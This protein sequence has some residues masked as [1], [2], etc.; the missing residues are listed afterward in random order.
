MAINAHRA[1]ENSGENSY[2]KNLNPSD[3]EINELRRAR[4]KI[5]LTLKSAFSDWENRIEAK[6]LFEYTA[7]ASFSSNLEKPKLSPKFRSQ[8]SYVY[9]TLNQP[10]HNP[11]QEMDFDDGMFLPTS[12]ITQDGGAHP[13][14]ASEGYFALVESA[15]GPLC[16]AEGWTLNPDRARPSCVRVSLNNGRSHIDIALYAIP[17]DEYHLLIE[18]AAASSRIAIND[19][20]DSGEML[21]DSVY[22]TI[23]ID[24]IMLAHRDEGWKISD[25]RKLEDW[26]V[27]AVKTHGEQLRRVSRY[28]KG[29]RDHTWESCRLSSIALM[30][31]V[32]RF[33]EESRQDH[34]GRDDLA[35]QAVAANLPTYLSQKIDNPVV[36]GRLDEGWDDVDNPCRREFVSQAQSLQRAIDQA[37]SQSKAADASNELRRLFGSHFPQEISLISDEGSIGAPA[38]VSAGVLGSLGSAEDAKSAVKIGGDD[39]YG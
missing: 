32:V 16:R 26:F 2:R 9:A 21:F 15:L 1:F 17:D 35:L 22:Q 27:S 36:E 14:V 7:V 33:F 37:L 19:S 25:P 39:R 29:W 5:R 10:T 24:Q 18:K 28:L 3:R 11:P 12:F 30:A 31:C 23:P 34:V 38:I 13:I 8:G 20:A 6:A 4:D